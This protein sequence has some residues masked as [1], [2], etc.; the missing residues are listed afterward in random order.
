MAKK[1]F[2]SKKNQKIFYYGLI[3]AAVIGGLYLIKKG[4]AGSRIQWYSKKF[5]ISGGKLFYFVDIINPSNSGITLN[6]IFLNFYKDNYLLGRVFFNT[7]TTIP[8]N[9]QVTISI[10]VTVAPVGIALLIKDLITN[11]KGPIKIRIT[12]GVKAENVNIPIDEKM[13]INPSDYIS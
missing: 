4:A 2:K 9:S 7:V 3:G 1:L 13:T 6:N 11:I 8:A 10:P 5:K 12:G